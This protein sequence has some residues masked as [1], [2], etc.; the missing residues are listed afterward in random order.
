MPWAF[1]IW[2][3]SSFSKNDYELL[4]KSGYSVAEISLD[5]PWPFSADFKNTVKQIA[6]LGLRIAFHAPWRDISL[7]SPYRDISRGSLEALKKVIDEVAD[8]RAE[9]MVFHIQTREEV[10]LDSEYFSQ[11]KEVVAE[12]ND[13]ARS[14]GIRAVLENTFSGVS[15]S[16]E[17][18]A[19]LLKYTGAGACLDIGRLLPRESQHYFSLEQ[20][21]KWIRTI[22][23]KIE[24]LH[25]HSLGRRKGRVTEHFSFLGNENLFS[26]IVKRTFTF[27]PNLVVTLEVFYTHAG[28]DVTAS[29]LAEMLTKFLSL[30]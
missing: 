21:E 20:I 26:T 8:T 28:N 3:K 24:V 1:T 19:E 2:N 13:Y 6:E 18:F 7:A 23:N 29:Y 16:P 17:S 10:K 4:I 14:K 11:V 15:E 22:S 5:Y 25:L 27:N 12:L 30:F 9:Y